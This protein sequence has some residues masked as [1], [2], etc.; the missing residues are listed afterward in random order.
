[1]ETVPPRAAAERLDRLEKGSAHLREF[2]HATLKRQRIEVTQRD[3]AIEDLRAELHEKVGER[4]KLIRALQ[5]E[6]H[7]KVGQRDQTIHRL[8][9]ELHEK[10]D[11]RDQIIRRLQDQLGRLARA[12]GEAEE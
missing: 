4:D 11:N 6:L 1:M 9:A 2:L 5:Q 3:Q 10:V 7:E 12:G 8:Q